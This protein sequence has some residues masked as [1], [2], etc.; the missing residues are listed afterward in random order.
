MST[1]WFNTNEQHSSNYVTGPMQ[2]YNKGSDGYPS[3]RLK[4]PPM[5]SWVSRQKTL[6]VTGVNDQLLINNARTDYYLTSVGFV[7]KMHVELTLKNNHGSTAANILPQYAIQ[8]VEILGGASEVVISTIR[9]DEIYLQRIH[10]NYEKVLRNDQAEGLSVTTYNNDTTLAFGASRK[11]LIEL[12]SFLSSNE[13][14][15]NSTKEKIILRITWSNKCCDLPNNILYVDSA[16]ITRG[17]ALESNHQSNDL[18][19]RKNGIWKY[20]FL[21]CAHHDENI[22]LTTNTQ[23]DIK[24]S[25]MNGYCAFMCILIRPSNPTFAQLNS[26]QVIDSLAILDRSGNI[27]GQQ[28]PSLELNDIVNQSF[29]GHILSI[30]PNIYIIPFCKSPDLAIQGHINGYTK[31]DS[32]QMLRIQTEGTITPGSFTVS[33]ISYFYA[34]VEINNGNIKSYKN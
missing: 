23:Y 9:D 1:D 21:E 25:A 16:I 12:K 6:P 34:T 18:S 3:N 32:Q 22:N 7:D 10:D 14:N 26:Y 24:L 8:K 27:V 4:L 5:N 20:G 2:L 17:T 33:I 28:I 19:I 13:L 11:Y 15:L 30:K 29:K 31:F